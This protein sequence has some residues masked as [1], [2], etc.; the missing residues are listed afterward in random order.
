MVPPNAITITNTV[1]R[2]HTQPSVNKVERST[3]TRYLDPGM[4]NILNSS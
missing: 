3:V 2:R 1:N 4:S